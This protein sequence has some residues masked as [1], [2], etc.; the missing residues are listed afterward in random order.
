MLLRETILSADICVKC[1]YKRVRGEIAVHICL[2]V[3]DYLRID[4]KETKRTSYPLGKEPG[5]W[6]L[7]D[8]LGREIFF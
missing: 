2:Y 6:H 4:N 3:S 8:R 5:I 7:G 1:L